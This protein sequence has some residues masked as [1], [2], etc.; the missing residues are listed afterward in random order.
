MVG[1][2]RLLWLSAMIYVIAFPMACAA[3]DK[4]GFIEPR[5]SLIANEGFCLDGGYKD[6]WPGGRPSGL[7]AWGSYCSQGDR[8]TGKAV[9]SAFIAPARFSLYLSGYPTNA[10]LDLELENLSNGEKLP[11]Q[12]RDPPRESWSR[13][14]FSVPPSWQGK[15]VRIVAE[16]RSTAPA[17]WLGFSEPLELGTVVALRQAA[18]LL[19]RAVSHFFLLMLIY[20]AVCAGMLLKGIRNEAV[21][22]FAGLAGIGASGYLI[23]WLWFVSP[24]LGHAISFFLPIAAGAYLFWAIRRIDIVDREI[25]K[26]LVGPAGLLFAASLMILAAGFIYG[27][28]ASASNTAQTRFSHHLPTD[29][30]APF[31]FAEGIRYGHIQKIRGDWHSSD[32]PPLE[33]GIALSQYPFMPQPRDLGY[34]VLGALLQSL[35]IPALWLFGMAFEIDRRALVA[36]LTAIIFSGFAIVNTFFVWPKLLAGAYEIA[37][38]A[39]L[40]AAALRPI[41]A[42]STLACIIAG[43]LAALGLLA[44]GG[45][46]FAL[47]GLALTVIVLK[48][49]MRLRSVALIVATCFLLYLPWF[50]YQK[51]YDPPGD[52]LLKWH[53]A[54]VEHPDSRSFTEILR[55]RYGKLTFQQVIYNKLA[56]ARL[57]IGHGGEYWKGIGNLLQESWR[58][59]WQRAAETARH[60]RGLT[61]F[62]CV[63]SLGFLIAG[64]FALLAG[65]G[66]RYRT[67]EWKSTG[68]IWLYVAL[69]L[70]VWCVLLFGPAKTIIHSGTYV[71][72]VLALAGSVFA[73]WAVS[74]RLAWTVIAIQIAVNLLIYGVFMR[75]INPNV[76]L[77][78]SVHYAVLGLA[79]ASLAGTVFLLRRLATEQGQR[80]RMDS[81]PDRVNDKH[82]SPIHRD[83]AVFM[84]RPQGMLDQ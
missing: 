52:Y 72:V 39:M 46:A 53:L 79:L 22:G 69:T 37:F 61:F 43:S 27:G 62:F 17:G 54:G 3:G 35:W 56:N 41:L 9:T 67:K 66:R 20:F 11:I 44:H 29:N 76:L 5:V 10:G 14:D 81:Q 64:P 74:R 28:M 24:R 7:K 26:A 36:A 57:V 60:L 31:V 65:I 84:K 48:R 73:L 15:R 6:V 18:V 50:L 30:A 47:L 40:L 71:T 80:E 23:F 45:S 12:P 83:A 77:D 1:P 55:S 51:L 33:T 32:R 19:G 70:I 63:P 42:D 21:A 13:F 49:R 4:P 16:D 59:D 68:I 8:T 2:D 34:T 38:A 78:G 75:S 25:L 82:W 58:G